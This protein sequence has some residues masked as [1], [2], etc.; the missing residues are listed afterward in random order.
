LGTGFISKGTGHG[1]RFEASAKGDGF[2]Q[3]LG[4]F[5][6]RRAAG[7][8]ILDLRARVRRKFEIEIVG[9]KFENFFAVAHVSFW[10]RARRPR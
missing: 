6:A 8:M 4:E 3:A 10:R 1:A 9:E 5:F 7:Q 2:P